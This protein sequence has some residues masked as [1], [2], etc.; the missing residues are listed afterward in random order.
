VKL[1][2]DLSDAADLAKESTKPRTVGD[3]TLLVLITR[4]RDWPESELGKLAL[5]SFCAVYESPDAP[6]K[7][8]WLDVTLP[9]FVR[10][11]ALPAMATSQMTMISL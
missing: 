10:K 11:G 7:L 1:E 6:P 2:R 5:I 8:R 4:K 3:V 9:A